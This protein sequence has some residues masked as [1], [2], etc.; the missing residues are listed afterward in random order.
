VRAGE[1]GRRDPEAGR[2]NI[3]AIDR[4]AAEGKIKPHIC[5]RFPLERAVDALRML[6]ERKVVGKVVIE[7]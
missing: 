1:Y 3:D 5:A 7:M 2:A 4:L 6:Q